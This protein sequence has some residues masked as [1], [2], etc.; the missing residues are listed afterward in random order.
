MLFD[1]VQRVLDKDRIVAHDPYFKAFGKCRREFVQTIFQLMSDSDRILS[2]L[3][4]YHERHGGLSVQT[5]FR[6][7]FLG[8]VLDVAKIIY[9]DLI[10]SPRGNNDISKLFG[11]FDLPHRPHAGFSLA[12]ID[13][14][15]RKFQ[16]LDL[17]TARNFR[18][19]YVIRTHLVR[20]DPNVYLPL[21]SANDRY[22]ANSVY[23]FDTFLDLR[24]RDL[25]HVANTCGRRDHDAQNGRSVTVQFLHRRLL[26]CFG[27]VWNNGLDPI[28]NLLCGDV[29]VLFKKK[30][31]EHL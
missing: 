9:L 6:T 8:T 4:R 26:G 19:R 12:L 5:S 10:I 23:R 1:R 20:I 22:L 31:N 3:F 16:V 14:A 18:R 15:A 11:F 13:P 24:L 30:L 2:G 27:K 25:C 29:H 17:Q 7:Q 21:A 28:L